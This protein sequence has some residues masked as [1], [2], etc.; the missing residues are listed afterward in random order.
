MAEVGAQLWL[1]AGVQSPSHTEVVAETSVVP[2]VFLTYV[3]AL[4]V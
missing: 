1:E 4:S 3:V 2:N